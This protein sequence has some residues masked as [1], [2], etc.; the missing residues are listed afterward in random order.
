MR[1]AAVGVFVLLRR[2]LL[3]CWK[4]TIFAA[5]IKMPYDKRNKLN[6]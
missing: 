2:F 4:K 6:G 3:N 5:L 1:I